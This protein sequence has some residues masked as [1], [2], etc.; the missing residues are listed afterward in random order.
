MVIVLSDFEVS[1][2]K[3]NMSKSANKRSCVFDENHEV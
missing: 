2:Q 3:P 1:T